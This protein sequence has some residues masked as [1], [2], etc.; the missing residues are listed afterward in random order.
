M[1][2]KER[3][4]VFLWGLGLGMIGGAL[5]MALS[6]GLGVAAGVFGFVSMMWS[7]RKAGMFEK[8]KEV[9]G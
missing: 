1:K 9:K 7:A 2:S 5:F 4:V 8:R 6:P 3:V